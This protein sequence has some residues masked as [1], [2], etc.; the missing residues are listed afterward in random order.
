MQALPKL[1]WICYPIRQNEV[2]GNNGV[3]EALC[4]IAGLGILGKGRKV[5]APAWP[6]VRVLTHVLLWSKTKGVPM[7]FSSAFLKCHFNAIFAINFS[8]TFL[9]TSKMEI[10]CL[11]TRNPSSCCD[12]LLKIAIINTKSLLSFGYRCTLILRMISSVVL[13]ICFH[14]TI[15]FHS[16]IFN[17][18]ERMEISWKDS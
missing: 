7:K 13:P 15:S 9:F 5:Y 1:Q 16:W 10:P 18:H 2:S 3:W 11:W 4:K 12:S 14:N 6:V 8:F 17:S